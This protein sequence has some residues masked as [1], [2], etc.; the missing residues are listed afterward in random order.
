MAVDER[1]D[2]MSAQLDLLVTEMAA[3]RARRGRWEELVHE[4]SPIARQAVSRATDQLQEIDVTVEDIVSF[5][6]TT[7]DALPFLEESI[8]TLRSLTE[9]GA[10][11]S[12]LSEPA[13]EY[14]TE[15]LDDLE[16][17]GYMAFA[18][19]SWGVADRVVTSFTEEDVRAL[20]DNIVLILNTVKEMTQPEIMSM[21]SRTIHT[22][23][24]DELAEPPS[25]FALLREMRDPDVRRGL[26]RV[27]TMLRSVGEPVARNT[28]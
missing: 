1:L 28:N 4:M 19:A 3:Q 24:G 13:T 20:G 26:A 25:V 14:L 22:V 16:G 6:R 15:R 18:K 27:L 7:A 2:R 21:L 8:K 9:L 10:A 5:A 23:Q 17:R 11:I 12:E